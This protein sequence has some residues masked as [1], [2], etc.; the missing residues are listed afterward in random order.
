MSKVIDGI[1]P[2][3]AVVPAKQARKVIDRDLTALEYHVIQFVLNP[4]IPEPDPKLDALA[5]ALFARWVGDE[6]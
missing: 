3:D 5:D 2:F 4:I 6:S 1:L